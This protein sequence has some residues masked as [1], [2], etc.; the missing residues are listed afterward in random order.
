MSYF[1]FKSF[2]C[3]SGECIDQKYWYHLPISVM[4]LTTLS[5]QVTVELGF[6]F[7][8]QVVSSIGK[9]LLLEVIKWSSLWLNYCA[10][11]GNEFNTDIFNIKKKNNLVW[12]S[13]VVNFFRWY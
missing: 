11:Y 4:V 12:I 2:H 3:G 9:L 10:A 5:P 8:A 13:Q 6:G 1:L 7:N